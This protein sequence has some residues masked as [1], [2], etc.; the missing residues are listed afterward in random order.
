MDD[1]AWRQER[2]AALT[3]PQGWLNLTDR[4]EIPT[5]PQR[6]G[7]AADNDLVLGAGP[8]HLGVLELKG[9]GAV[10]TEPDGQSHVFHPTAGFAQL[11]VSTVLLELHPADGVMALRVRDLTLSPTITLRYFPYDP[12][13]RLLADWQALSAVEDRAIGQRGAGQTR[14]RVTHRAAFSQG[15]RS[16][17]L[18]PTHWKSDKPM[19]V[20][21]DQTSGRETYGAGR[22]LLGEI[23]G[24]KVLLDFNRAHNPPCA[25]TDLAICPLPPPEN[26]FDFPIRAGELAP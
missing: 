13:W 12:A 1:T 8:D 18:V 6:V 16:L 7:R 9:G 2:L 17:T 10:L 22:F 5:G 3:G 26:R 24:D 25:F 19:F 11:Q 4:I 20:L 23:Q 21:R 14:V 15:G